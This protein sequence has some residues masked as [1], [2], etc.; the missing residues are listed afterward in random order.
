MSRHAALATALLVALLT[1]A[2]LVP[3]RPVETFTTPACMAAA[4]RES[5]PPIGAMPAWKPPTAT[6]QRLWHGGGTITGPPS[7]ESRPLFALGADELALW[8]R[9]VFSGG[10]VGLMSPTIRADLDSAETLRLTVT[11]GAAR[12]LELTTSFARDID[13]HQRGLRTIRFAL[14][15]EDPEGTVVLDA[16]LS[17]VLGGNW[18]DE[19]FPDRRLRRLEVRVDSEAQAEG[20]SLQRLEIL[21][22]D[23]AFAGQPAGRRT[24]EVEG[25]LRPGWFLRG[26]SQVVLD[27][28]ALPGVFRA[29]AA[30]IG[31]ATLVVSIG[32]DSRRVDL[33]ESWQAIS[34]LP[35][36]GGRVVFRAEG[37]GIVLLGSPLIAAPTASDAPNV[38]VLL[39]DTLRA[40]HLGAWG[41]PL[42]ITPNLDALADGGAGFGLAQSTASWTKPA[43]PTLMTG[44]WATTHQVGARSYTDL[45]PSTV[46]TLQ[47]QLADAGWRTASFSASPLGSTLS[48]LERDFDLALPPR[49]WRGQTGLLG[50]PSLDHLTES[51]LSW[52]EE[53]DGP[54]FA[55]L[56][57][58]EAH[59]WRRGPY[60]GDGGRP[61]YERAIADLDDKVGRLR[62]A[63]Q[64]RGL[65]DNTLIVVTADHGEAFGDH[66]TYDH[67]TSLYQS[68]VHIPLLFWAR[69]LPASWSDHPVSLADVAPTILDLLGAPSLQEANGQ[70][71]LPTIA[72]GEAVHDWVPSARERFVWRYLDPPIYALTAANHMKLIATQDQDQL[73][74]LGDDLCEGRTSAW[75]ALGLDTTLDRWLA[76][77]QQAR[78]TFAERHPGVLKAVRADDVRM[79]EEMGYLQ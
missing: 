53:G 45:L 1:A 14:D 42:G 66:G 24:L 2:S 16:P 55:Y 28:Q 71:L 63:L 33:S 22:R 25:A 49:H 4:L 37:E 30:A 50:H 32:E 18:D 57:V 46:P 8:H 19:R 59:A 64:A 69:D 73:F 29:S 26:G 27:A 68:Q 21:G 5:R 3:R 15:G 41:S 44:I 67:G 47:G 12:N 11:P 74:D 20:M 75:P 62:D 72:R 13:R 61:P 43:I 40:D 38:I 31:E 77:Q 7:P 36:Q 79:L 39:M 70:S 34:D 48:G 60:Q 65:L 35:T 10:E 6:I 58:M 54:V 78:E 23:A 52:W 56:H 76:G 9:F 17:E 51:L